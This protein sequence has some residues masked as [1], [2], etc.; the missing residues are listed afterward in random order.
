M[1]CWYCGTDEAPAYERDHQ[2]PITRGGCGPGDVWACR[3][4]NRLKGPA[5]VEEFG[6]RLAQVLGRPV[7]FA[8]EGGANCLDSVEVQRARE[9]LGSQRVLKLTGSLGG[10]LLNAVM[11]LRGRGQPTLTLSTVGHEAIRR[12]LARLAQLHNGGEPFPRYERPHQLD[13]FA[14]EDPELAAATK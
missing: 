9:I 11:F 1:I 6:A 10:E 5:T 14:A 7:R 8:G 3:S 2:L 12:E 13:L 4:C